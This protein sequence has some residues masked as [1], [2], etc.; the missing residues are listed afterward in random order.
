MQIK[1]DGNVIIPLIL[2]LAVLFIFLWDIAEAS[3]D[4]NTVSMTGTVTAEVMVTSVDPER[5]AVRI[6]A[7]SQMRR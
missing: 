2:I 3:E 7:C 6:T 1:I 5:R 4:E